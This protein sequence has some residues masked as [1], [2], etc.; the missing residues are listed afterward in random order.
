MCLT[1]ED[2]GGN[3]VVGV[4][5]GVLLVLFTLVIVLFIITRYLINLFTVYF[6]SRMMEQ[7]AT[8]DCT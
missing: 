8:T 3:L 2:D 5:S 4:T 1:E 6:I 7:Y